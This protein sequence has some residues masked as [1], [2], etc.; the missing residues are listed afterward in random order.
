[1]HKFLKFILEGNFACFGQFLC[2]SS[3]IFHCTHNSGICHTD[4]LT[5]CGQDQDE[6]QFHPG[7]AHKL[8]ANLYDI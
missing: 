2:P 6:T 7:P 8:S 4:L 5:A 3:G 1:M